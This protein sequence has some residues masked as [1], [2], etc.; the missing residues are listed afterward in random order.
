MSVESIKLPINP[1]NVGLDSYPMWENE[2]VEVELTLK[3]KQ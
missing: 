3:V 2:P 1:K